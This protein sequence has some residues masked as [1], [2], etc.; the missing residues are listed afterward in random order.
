MVRSTGVSVR[1]TLPAHDVYETQYT[2]EA[3]FKCPNYCHQIH[4]GNCSFVEWLDTTRSMS[5]EWLNMKRSIE[6]HNMRIGGVCR[7]DYLRGRNVRSV[8]VVIVATFFQIFF[9]LKGKLLVHPV[10]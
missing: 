10:V 7:T 5:Q 3:I 8:N 9:F 4:G 1:R 2:R 6:R